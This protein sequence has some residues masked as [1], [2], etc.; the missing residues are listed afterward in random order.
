MK[1]IVIRCHQFRWFSNWLTFG[2]LLTKLALVEDGGLDTRVD[3]YLRPRPDGIES[4]ADWLFID[5]V[6]LI[7]K[8]FCNNLSREL[9]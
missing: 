9:G 7:G 1:K 3:K 2:V 4:A 8:L 6:Q 5:E